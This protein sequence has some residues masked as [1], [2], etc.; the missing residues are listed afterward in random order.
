MGSQAIRERVVDR[1]ERIAQRYLARVKAY[2]SDTGVRA[3]AR[4]CRGEDVRTSLVDLIEEEGA[5][6]VVL[7]ARGQG[8]HH[9]AGLRYGSVAGYLMAQS[10]VPLLIVRP[11][12]NDLGDYLVENCQLRQPTGTRG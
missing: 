5:D 6:L 10:S 3:R 8:G 7:S 1:N 12:E 2:L 11:Q 9:H 4:L